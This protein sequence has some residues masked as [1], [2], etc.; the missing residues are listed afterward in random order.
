[1]VA[2]GSTLVAVGVHY[3]GHACEYDISTWL[4]VYGAVMLVTSLFYLQAM[5]IGDG[6]I[7]S[8]K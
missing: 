8:S 3:A 1:M 6:V 4:I 2:L 5:S 7:Y